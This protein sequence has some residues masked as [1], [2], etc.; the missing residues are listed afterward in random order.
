M[1]KSRATLTPEQIQRELDETRVSLPIVSRLGDLFTERKMF[2]SMRSF[3]QAGFKLIA[4]APHK[5]MSG[6]HKHARGYLF[7]KYNNDRPGK[8]QIKN[9]M[10]RIEGARLLRNFIAEH[11]LRHVVAPRKW[12]Y[13]LPESFPE[14]YLVVVDKLDLV[15]DDATLRKYARIREEHLRELAM[16]LFYFRGLNS[17]TKNLPF[18]EDGEIAFV[19]TERWHS[20]KDYLRLIG[21]HL[22]NDRRKQAEDLFKELRRQGAR[23]FVSAFK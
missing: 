6:S 23:P 5:I 10:R 14:R 20:D 16:V 22:P 8:K 2:N 9:Y 18:T 17:W 13:E 4:H 21:D 12:L 11:G 3:E 15:S 19:D 7:K 1:T